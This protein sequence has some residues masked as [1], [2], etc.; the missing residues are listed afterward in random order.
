MLWRALGHIEHGFY[1]D[2]GACS[3]DEMSVTKLFSERGWHGINVEPN[4]V[5][6]EA[7]QSRRPRDTNLPIALGAY[8]GEIEMHLFGDTG[9]STVDN[10]I[11]ESHRVNWK[12]T[13]S[14]VKLRRLADIWRERV[15]QDQPVHFL[16]IDVEG[17]ER[18]VLLGADWSIQRPWIVV[19]EATAPLS[20]EPTHA[21]WEGILLDADY[22]F[23]YFDGLNRFYIARE[24]SELQAAFSAP[25]NVFDDYI[26]AALVER[27]SM[28]AERDSAIAL[29]HGEVREAKDRLS[30]DSHAAERLRSDVIELTES[31]A[32]LRGE[33]ER[34]TGELQQHMESSAKLRAE[35]EHRTNELRRRAEENTNLLQRAANLERERHVF[36]SS[37]SWRLTQPLRLMN[38]NITPTQRNRLRRIVK[39]AWWMVTPWRLPA[40]FRFIRE[41]NAATVAAGIVPMVT[42][43]Q[44][45]YLAW[46]RGRGPTEN[47]IPFPRGEAPVISF[48]LDVS[49]QDDDVALSRTLASLRGQK[50][51]AWE[52]L[53]C[54][55]SAS[56]QKRQSFCSLLAGDE[57]IQ[58]ADQEQ[59]CGSALRE[60]RGTYIAVLD[61]GDLLAP[62][63]LDEVAAAIAASPEADILYSD[64]DRQ[65]AGSVREQPY[66][67]PC[68][69]PDLLSAFNYFGRLTLLRHK[70]AVEV[71]GF[72]QGAGSAFEWDLNL[73]I[74][75]I[76]QTVVRIPKV[77]CHR[78]P[79]SDVGRPAAETSAAAD[80]RR[81]IQAYWKRHGY[82]AEALT[83]PDGTQLATWP[84]VTEPRVSVV[85][86][87]KDKAHL[88]RMSTTGLLQLTNYRNLELI[89]VD[90]GSTHPETLALYS[91]LGADPR[92]KILNFRPKFNYSAACNFGAA[93]ATGQILLFL[94]NDVEVISEDW[95]AEMVRFA[96]R[97]GVGCVG[98]KLLFPSLELQHGGVTIGP[99]LAALAYRSGEALGFELFG[100]PHHPRNWMAVMGACQMVTRE[101]FD[102][103][104][105]FDESYQIA[106]SD[107]AL[108]LQLWR[109]GYRTAY[110]PAGA[111][112][113]HEGATRGHSNPAEDVQRL[114]DDI[115]IL[116]ID[117]DPYLHP[118][119]NGAEAIPS[120]RPPGGE[121]PAETL[122][123]MI[124]EVGSYE[125]IPT[126][127]D[128]NCDGRVLALTGRS[129][130]Q[131]LW[132][133]QPAY[134]VV[135][136]WSAARWTLDLLRRRS[137]I[138][139]RFPHALSDGQKGTFAR[140][141]IKE[142][143]TQFGLPD[144]AANAFQA[145]F[146]ANLGARARS[147]F[148]RRD[149][150]RQM[151]PHGLT[152]AGRSE[153]FRWFILH[154]RFEENIRL[155]E[156]WWLFQ[157]ANERPEREIVTAFCVTRAWQTMFPE[158]ASPF[159]A[160][161]FARWFA[162]TYRA[163]GAWLNPT[164]WVLPGSPADQIRLA[165]WS[166]ED[167]RKTHPLAL[168]E[169]VAALS[170][171]DWLKSGAVAMEPWVTTWLNSINRDNMAVELTRPGVNMF[172][173]FR[174]PSGLRISA[175]A[176]VEGLRE[177][178]IGLSLR[179]VR[180]GA[181]DDP[182][183][184]HFVGFETY[185]V[186]IVHAQ[187]EPFFDHVFESVDL[188]ER[189][190]RSYRIAYW[191]WE[192]NT[193][194]DSWR[195]QASLVD[196]V[197]AATEFV[198]QGLREKLSVPV[199]TLFPGVRL[200]P[201]EARG[202]KY[203]G[204]P[205]NETLYLFTFHMMS[206]MER[207][208]PLGLIRAFKQAF[209]PEEPARLVLKT[210]FGS[211]HPKE[212]E[213]LRQAAAG[214]RITIID[215]VYSPNDVLAITEACDV[216][217]SLHRSEG[218]GL[219]MAEA[220]LMGKPVVATGYS[221]NTE[222]MD[223]SNS[224]LV[225]Y[226]LVKVGEPI[227][228]YEAGYEWAQ[229]SED[230]AAKLLRRLYDEPAFAHELG[231]KA[232][233]DAERRLSVSEAGRRIAARLAEIEDA[234]SK[235]SIQ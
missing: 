5:H 188:S 155:E 45:K 224:L 64:E 40:R 205:E 66:L 164:N 36:L 149:D 75:D 210:S 233:I 72:D 76:A 39:A 96:Q 95:L 232:K 3:P 187:P 176:I 216:Y 46:I 145:M 48:L 4:P 35:L 130:A 132:T 163:D 63:A 180:T 171:L 123:R 192:F 219:T 16:K 43:P 204:L 108:C 218:L 86:P 28:I 79:D 223:E 89:I 61:A 207:K 6:F 54:G 168:K 13:I 133:P 34:R 209:R 220:M 212:M 229:P 128:L 211:H 84:L 81:T 33:L 112:V 134:K 88:L 78:R 10:V 85:I 185:D 105:G 142:G 17:F 22:L 50:R 47:A 87:T 52:V 23:V 91:E 113:H 44:S 175:E 125:A 57:R 68:F 110:V 129:R 190:S 55:A 199:R 139:A 158:G 156:I 183:H 193:I 189:D 70:L 56:R 100:S 213:K 101:A 161:R 173:H 109:A 170:F 27:D 166:R 80:A 114:A 206:I 38:K 116:G 154:G 165:W 226:T 147:V 65:S 25:P 98:V 77:L 24:H 225:D 215:E 102:A 14:S 118:D 217:V 208:N 104:G 200:A 138:R 41:R 8:D 181:K 203:F 107:V 169:Q 97:P 82:Q 18:E 150:I 115:R 197:W 73:R 67:K 49:H 42:T 121:G 179:D 12:E 20:A 90:T 120:L 60:A 71:G 162:A 83:Q 184:E 227:P 58:I 122:R 32:K 126:E 127:L 103:V 140:W 26:P 119:L 172:G 37:K 136:C 230:H 186:T 29:L 92:V 30:E 15:S 11:A 53:V 131:V 178:G 99:H 31:A 124:S 135:D 228:P 151:W 21:L 117:E 74:A 146:D 214:S 143:C 1:I 201:Y 191:Y 160:D 2:V 62:A 137:D 59:T 93:A 202:R 106:M 153:L 182:G 234:R 231:L 198:A 177:I 111:L 222:F 69:S 148:L 196:E 144:E 51:T 195:V 174:Y 159:G 194:P 235:D 167:W 7:L 221:G 141:L 9:L 152:P 94:N 157:E 19:I